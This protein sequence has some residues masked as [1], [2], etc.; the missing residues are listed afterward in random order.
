MRKLV[1]C[2]TLKAGAN[3]KREKGFAEMPKRRDARRRHAYRWISAL[4]RWRAEV[5][6]GCFP[7]PQRGH[8]EENS[9]G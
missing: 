2:S 1:A 6:F 5:I 8:L 7:L 3:K 4:R 9:R